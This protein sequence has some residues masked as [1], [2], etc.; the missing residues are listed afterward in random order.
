MLPGAVIEI[1]TKEW[2]MGKFLRQCNPGRKWHGPQANVSVIDRP[3]SAF[4]I[5]NRNSSELNS[6]NLFSQSY[7]CEPLISKLM[8]LSTITMCRFFSFFILFNVTTVAYSVKHFSDFEHVISH[9]IQH[10][11]FVAALDVLTK[12]ASIQP[13]PISVPVVQ[14]HKVQQSNALSFSE[15]PNTI[16]IKNS[17]LK[18][19]WEPLPF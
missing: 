17:F 15:N 19:L 4:A 5:F 2:H 18:K 14:L 3:K 11:D 9:H 6:A 7:R 8:P 1:R 12:Q 10:D 16:P 13:Q